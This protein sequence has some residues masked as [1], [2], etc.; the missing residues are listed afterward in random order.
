MRP[1]ATPKSAPKSAGARRP[2][3]VPRVLV[4]RVRVLGVLAVMAAALGACERVKGE[5]AQKKTEDKRE[6]RRLILGA[7]ASP[8]ASYD[9]PYEVRSPS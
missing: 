4:P 7:L 3:L 8:P 1:T 9:G 6:R 5:C 2:G